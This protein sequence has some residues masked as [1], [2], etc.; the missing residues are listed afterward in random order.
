VPS[1]LRHPVAR[2]VCL[3]A[4]A[5][6]LADWVLFATLVATVDT[7]VGGGPWATALVLLVRIV[8]G[9]LLAPVA[10]RRVDGADLPRLLARHE[11]VR[12]GAIATL[13]AAFATRTAPAVLAGLLALEFAAAMR[14][15][16]RESLTSRH[17]PARTFT[18][19]NTATAVIAYG[20]LP[21]GPVLVAWLGTGVGWTMAAGGALGLTAAYRRLDPGP[22]SAAVGAEPVATSDA[23]VLPGT[24]WRRVTVAAALGVLPTVALFALGPSLAGAWL[25][26]RAATGPLYAAA[27][28]GGGVGFALANL[29]RLRADVAMVVATVGLGTAA[30]GVWLPGLVLLGIGAGAAYLD[31]QT[32]L[33]HTAADPS[34]F[35]A[36]FAVLKGASAVGVAGAPL[37][38]AAGSL[39][40]VLLA[41]A[42]IATIGA[43]VA[44]PTSITVFRRALRTVLRVAAR[45]VL[46]V[47]V[48]ARDRRVAG[49]GVVVS[50]HPHWLDGV[51]ALLADDELRPVARRQAHPGARLGIWAADAVVTTRPADPV[52]TDPVAPR[53]PAFAEAATHLRDGGRVWLAPEGGAHT[54]AR[55]RPP[56]SGAVRMAHLAGVPVQP[57]GITWGDGRTGPD[58]AGWRP[59]RRCRVRVTW[60][61][62]ITTTGDVAADGTRMM[63]ALA[64]VAEMLPPAVTPAAA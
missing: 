37:L 7:L 1:L 2:F 35:A 24:G 30:A 5:G 49:P 55:L 13:A 8:P 39:E 44:T 12:L 14:A 22:A 32:R 50:N 60:G 42:A 61:T 40:A 33:Q 27:L 47:E 38:A 10:A 15:A 48:V 4:L 34:Q 31:L 26:D 23:P 3:T 56:R 16:A 6:S 21:V 25:G 64:A 51:V 9:V 11:L 41:G 18:A 46:R 57:L 54:G 29:R 45:A 28:V 19:L 59:W 36:A 62:P 53:R 17:V 20:L 58:L 43:V 52:G 63:V